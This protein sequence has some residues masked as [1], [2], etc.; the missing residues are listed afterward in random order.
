[1]RSGRDLLTGFPR[2]R[3]DPGPSPA[4]RAF[5]LLLSLVKSCRSAER[6]GGYTLA[7]DR[8]LRCIFRMSDE[9]QCIF[10]YFPDHSDAYFSEMSLPSLPNLLWSCLPLC[11]WCVCVFHYVLDTS[12]CVM[13]FTGIRSQSV[14]RLALLTMSSGEQMLVILTRS[15][16]T[17]FPL[18]AEQFVSQV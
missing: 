10:T 7:L 11:G 15:D 18:Y 6:F 5:P 16:R 14:P 17:I 1:M 9:E 3:A 13:C 4:V 12:P 2:R 8:A